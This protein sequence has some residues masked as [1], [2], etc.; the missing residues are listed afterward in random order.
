MQLLSRVMPK[1][2]TV[3]MSS[4]H[5]SDSLFAHNDGRAQLIDAV[6]SSRNAMLMLGGDQHECPT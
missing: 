3:F 1:K 2:F 4:C 6:G 5:H